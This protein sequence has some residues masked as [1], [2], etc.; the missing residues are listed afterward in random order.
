V[1]AV[2]D[3]LVVTVV[4]S[5][6]IARWQFMPDLVAAAR[7]CRG[8]DKRVGEVFSNTNVS[9]K[10]LCKRRLHLEIISHCEVVELVVWYE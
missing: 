7:I 10:A 5:H 2:S 4:L 1:E 8:K 9:L 6:E 3:V